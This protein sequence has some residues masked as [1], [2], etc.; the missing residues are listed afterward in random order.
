MPPPSMQMKQEA[1]YVL[2]E[3][4]RKRRTVDEGIAAV[5]EKL[6]PFPESLLDE[7]LLARDQNRGMSLLSFAAQ[8]GNKEWFEEVL[9][10]IRK[11]VRF[12]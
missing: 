1:M 3:S 8:S 7:A 4:I 5:K 12:R 2:R 6:D 9:K 11:K 10:R